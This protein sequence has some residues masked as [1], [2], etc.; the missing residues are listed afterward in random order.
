[1]GIFIHYF[2]ANEK[3]AIRTSFEDE[4][5]FPGVIGLIDGTHIRIRAPEDDPDAYVNRKKFFSFNIQ[6]TETQVYKY[7]VIRIDNIPLTWAF[8]YALCLQVVCDN[9]MIFTDVLAGWPGS[10]HDSRVLRNSELSRTAANKFPGDTHL[11]GD[12]A[13]PC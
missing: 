7:F 12:G 1:M 9:N 2:T 4:G 8:L 3:Q 13:T 5:G 6:V 11:L 10:V